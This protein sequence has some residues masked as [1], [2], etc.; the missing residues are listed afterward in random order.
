MFD[1]IALQGSNTRLYTPL[2]QNG[3]PVRYDHASE[4]VAS[5]LVTEHVDELQVKVDD[6]VVVRF[7]GQNV[8]VKEVSLKRS[9]GRGNQQYYSNVFTGL[10]VEVGFDRSCTGHTYIAVEDSVGDLIF[11]KCWK[12]AMRSNLQVTE[13]ESNEF[14]EVL[15]VYTDNPVEARQILT[16]DFMYDLYKWWKGKQQH[17]RVSFVDDRMYVLFADNRVRTRPKMIGLDRAEI[18]RHIESVALPLLHIFH[19]AEDVRR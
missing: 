4:I 14:E 12:P 18:Q 13:L 11:G 5:G 8:S 9:K 6:E 7:N 10:F 1:V 16:P 15:K 2:L 19:L 3:R 17:I